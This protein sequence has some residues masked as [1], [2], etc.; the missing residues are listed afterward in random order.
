MALSAWIGLLH[1]CGA[2][3]ASQSSKRMAV[4]RDTGHV[5]TYD[6]RTHGNDTSTDA[7]MRDAITSSTKVFRSRE[8]ELQD[9]LRIHSLVAQTN[10]NN[11]D[12][13][14]VKT[15]AHDDIGTVSPPRPS[16]NSPPVVHVSFD[17]DGEFTL[18]NTK[19]GV[20]KS[21]GTLRVFENATHCLNFLHIPKTAG[22]YVEYYGK[23]T[24]NRQW[25]K[26]D[27]AL[28]CTN[29]TMNEMMGY[30]MCHMK[31][32]SWCSIHHVP[33]KLDEVLQQSYAP[34]E[35]FC[36]VRNPASRF[37]SQHMEAGG[38][39]TAEA[40]K[41]SVDSKLE[42]VIKRPYMDV[43][44]FVP[45]VEYWNEG[46]SCNHVLK[47]ET[48]QADFSSLMQRF[49][50]NVVMLPEQN[51]KHCQAPFDESSLTKIQKHYAADYKAFGYSHEDPLD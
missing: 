18:V 23:T 5:D 29:M 49:G 36:T 45:Q 11:A 8:S 46:R 1:I 7:T 50:L 21:F 4:I 2:T 31:D 32:G 37:R 27:R 39:C 41:H 38:E 33:P 26:H 24:A 34:C 47:Q 12:G 43:C 19:P 10:G 51:S 20:T 3:S 42:E 6:A 48:F 30:P 28:R 15:E 17:D 44:H 14:P 22:T 25:G 35:T 9:S 40:L 16:T 13:V